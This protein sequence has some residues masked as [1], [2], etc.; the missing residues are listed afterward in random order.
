MP[1]RTARRA[2]SF[3]RCSTGLG[4]KSVNKSPQKKMGVLDECEE[5]GTS[6]ISLKKKEGSR[7][8]AELKA[9][10]GALRILC[11]IDR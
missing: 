9:A 5:D 4:Q 3:P 6:R 7:T 1:A 2:T 11:P 10:Q 8:R